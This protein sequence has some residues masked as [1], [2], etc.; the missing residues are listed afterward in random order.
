MTA[1][2][3]EATGCLRRTK[4]DENGKSQATENGVRTTS[5]DKTMK[6]DDIDTTGLA[7]RGG[8]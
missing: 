3:R 7:I 6:H 5:H 4:E 1:D 8:L 2:E